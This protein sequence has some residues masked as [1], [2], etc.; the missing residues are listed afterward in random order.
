VSRSRGV[1]A[2]LLVLATATACVT[3][4]A[5]PRRERRHAERSAATGG[6]RSGTMGERDPRPALGESGPSPATGASGPSGPTGGGGAAIELP[7]PE[8]RVP[9]K[10]R[11]LVE[12]IRT[13]FE[14]NRAAIDAWT[15]SG[16]SARWPVAEDVVLWTLYEQRIH[17]VL[18]KHAGL[19][20]EVVKRLPRRLAA[21][22]RLLAGAGRAFYE[23]FKPVERVP[24]FRIRK[25]RPADELLTYFREAQDRFDVHWEVL[26]AIMLVE[27]RM[28]RIRSSSSAG[29][30]GPMQFLPS[31]WAAY[32]MG[33]D[34]RDPR[35]AIMG[36][37]N[38]LR[39]SGAPRDY[40]RALHAY[41]PV[42]AYVTGVWAYAK[43]MMRDPV[44]YYA[45]YNWQVY[46]R[47]TSGDVRLSGPGF[48]V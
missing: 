13:T 20:R 41:N 14:H 8:A 25:P 3:S 7:D 1:I 33:G 37:A 19:T 38:Y 43:A 9:R 30:Q 31:T 36:A 4:E 10:P 48:S 22:T 47:T 44:A 15:A 6:G 40:R 39:A 28:G 23:H 11:R 17:R 12:A 46:V 18:A 45:L 27:T 16:G 5:A 26:A 24:D 34:I 2:L 35:D 29:A 21:Q 32:G 42:N